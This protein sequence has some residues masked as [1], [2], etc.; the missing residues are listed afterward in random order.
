MEN[1]ENLENVEQES[2]ADIIADIKANHVPKS[3]YE[4]LEADY[5]KVLNAIR[6]NEE[7]EIKQEEKPDI[8]QLRRELYTEDC[9]ELNDIQYVQKTLQ[10]RQ[11]IIDE[12]GQDPFVPFG[13]QHG[14]EESDFAT[15]ERAAQIFQECVDYADGDNSL[16]IAE[17]QRRTMDINPISSRQSRRSR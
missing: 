8:N 14:P 5:N 9:N 1:L 11:A 10:L 12:G 2:T 3:K 4:R 16:F 7:I 6:N 13:K 15:A 17:L